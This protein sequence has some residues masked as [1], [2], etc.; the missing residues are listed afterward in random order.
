MFNLNSHWPPSSIPLAQFGQGITREIECPKHM[1]GRII[2]KGG[3][4]VKGLQRQF[5]AS[6]QIEQ[7]ATP[8]KV[9]ITG[10]PDAVMAAEHAIMGLIEDR[11]MGGGG[12]M[13]GYGGGR[14]PFGGPAPYGGGGGGANS[15]EATAPFLR[16]G[17]GGGGGST[18]YGWGG[19]T[20]GETGASSAPD[21][22]GRPSASQVICVHV[23]PQ[24][25]CGQGW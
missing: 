25:V 17:G 6:I 13:G 21:D 5:A 9:T 22:N 24:S 16:R 1:V 18:G 2:G 7:N 20:G 3:E 19:S 23:C 11:P 4:T 14:P 8:C 10:P 15:R 12:P